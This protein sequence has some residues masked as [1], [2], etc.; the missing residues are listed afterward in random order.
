MTDDAKADMQRIDGA[1]RSG[2]QGWKPDICVYHGGCDD[3]FGAAWVVRKKW[4]DS[5]QFVPGAY[6]GTQWPSGMH[7]RNV[8]FVDF[9]LKREQMIEFA[10]GG[11]TGEVPRSIVV[12]DHHKTAEAE[13]RDW[14]HATLALA[15]VDLLAAKYCTETGCPIVA[16]F[17]MER[18]GARLAWEFCFPGEIVP[19]LI[20]HIED[21]DLWRYKYDTTAYVSA[22]L[23][24]YP[25]H[26]DVWDDLHAN[27]GRLAIEGATI[28]RGYRKNISDFVRNRYWAEVG[29]HRVPVVNVPYHY[30]SDVANELLKAEPAAPFAACWFR[31]GDGKVQWSLRSSD[32]RLDV[33][34]VAKA[35]G[36]GGHRNAAGFEE[37]VP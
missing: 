13:L 5:V 25:Q 31:R 4:G 14:V 3:G 1:I 32:G 23:R 8:L 20:R 22:A 21:R 27:F 28:L 24:T 35:K 7:G 36:G 18:S 26:F 19:P 12:L 29:G 30:A 9:S 16:Q 34:E 2:G 10:N 6:S 37:V 33:S 17:D 15:D 11:N